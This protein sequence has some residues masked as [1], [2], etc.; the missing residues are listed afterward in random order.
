MG[1]SKGPELPKAPTFQADPSA[2]TGIPDLLKYGQEL[3]SG[4]FGGRLSWL[5]PTISNDNTA[6]SLAFAQAKLQP[7]FRDTLQQ[8]TNQ[9][10]ANGQLNSST[11]TDALA[12]SQSDL[13]SQYQAILSQ[14]AIADNNQSN[15]N[16]LA[17][18]GQG[19]NSIQNA[20][21]LGLSNQGQTNDFNLQNYNNQVA[22]AIAGQGTGSNMFGG[23]GTALGTG[24]GALLALPTGGLSVL[25]GAGIGGAIGGGLGGTIDASRGGTGSAG[26]SGMG[27]GLGLLGSS[28]L[29]NPLTTS[30]L[31]LSAPNAGAFASDNPF[32]SNSFNSGNSDVANL[33]NTYNFTRN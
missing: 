12:R 24:L 15:T 14:Q 16:R 21:Q 23:L 33:L 22:A 2:A 30:K 11:F 28:M 13:N 31:G 26:F 6:N 9:A 25:A 8:I 29:A 7:Q 27:G 19:L 5:K 3:S 32:S 18:F 10:A 4:D 1:K 17:L 20:S